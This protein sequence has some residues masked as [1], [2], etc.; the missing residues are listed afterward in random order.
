MSFE[1]TGNQII[2]KKIY[3]ELGLLCSAFHHK[4]KSNFPIQCEV[5]YLCLMPSVV[6]YEYESCVV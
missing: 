5:L 3:T 6:M 4:N 2:F 1:A